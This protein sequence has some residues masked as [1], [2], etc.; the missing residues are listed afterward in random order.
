MD[1]RDGGGGGDGD[2]TDARDG[3][4]PARRRRGLASADGR[5]HNP[6]STTSARPPVLAE[7]DDD[8]NDDKVTLRA[9]PLPP[10][11][12]SSP[13]DD[14]N[15]APTPTTE[16]QPTQPF[17]GYDTQ[18]LTERPVMSVRPVN[19]PRQGT[20]TQA[21]FFERA[22]KP[23]PGGTGRRRMPATGEGGEV[24]SPRANDNARQKDGAMANGGD[25]SPGILARSKPSSTTD[26]AE[27]DAIPTWALEALEASS[28]AF[29]TKVFHPPHRSVSTFDRSPFQLMTLP[30]NCF[31]FLE[32]PSD[33]VVADLDV[34]E[35]AD[36]RYEPSVFE[37]S[38]ADGHQ[39]LALYVRTES[40]ARVRLD[41]ARERALAVTRSGDVVR[42]LGFVFRKEFLE[43]ASTVD[44]PADA[45]VVVRWEMRG[46]RLRTAKEVPVLRAEAERFDADEY[47]VPMRHEERGERS[48]KGDGEEGTE[49]LVETFDVS[50]VVGV[51]TPTTPRCC[52]DSNPDRRDGSYFTW[53]QGVADERTTTTIRARFAY[54]HDPGPS[55]WTF[56]GFVDG[57][58]RE[59]RNDRQVPV[60]ELLCGCGGTSEGLRRSVVP[61]TTTPR[62]ARGKRRRD[63]GNGGGS[64]DDETDA[65]GEL[66]P[67]KRRRL[68]PAFGLDANPN[69]V[70]TFNKNFKSRYPNCV[71]RVA[72]MEWFLEKLTAGADGGV[73][74]EA[75]SIHWFP[76]DRVCVVNADP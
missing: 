58:A 76:Y 43:K 5:H 1:E 73:S 67:V 71:A 39:F 44:D 29:Y 69:A 8:E 20:L 15:A 23:P 25:D 59:A 49:P 22:K 21:P 52:D 57:G 16:T 36:G 31:C 24:P 3:G 9:C 32:W 63:A 75:R 41:G 11:S 56:F 66:R 4:G 28:G 17:L 27:E 55:Q 42:V 37:A 46:V 33:V 34:R 45:R 68:L 40:G 47:F 30:L 6:D 12:R 35:L 60:V 51:A 64:S 7:G 50:D 65:A 14:A 61:G 26:E 18:Q 13:A 10:A 62:G 2:G 19:D 70:N 74:D 72:T 53:S 54:F 48:H 38:H